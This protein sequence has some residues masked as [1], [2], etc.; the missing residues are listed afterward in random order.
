M[1]AENLESFLSLLH[2]EMTGSC[3]HSQLF[4]GL[5]LFFLAVTLA[6]QTLYKN[7]LVHF[8]NSI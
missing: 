7:V 4:E 8:Q 5:G 3:H 1:L 2:A 6:F